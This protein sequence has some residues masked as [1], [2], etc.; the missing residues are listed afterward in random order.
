MGVNKVS[1]QC[2]SIFKESVRLKEIAMIQESP[3]ENDN[4]NQSWLFHTTFKK[5]IIN[6]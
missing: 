2:Y 6:A 3:T 5:Q 1:L 4:H